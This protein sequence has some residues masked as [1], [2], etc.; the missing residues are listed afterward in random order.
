MKTFFTIPTDNG[1]KLISI[2]TSKE[3]DKQRMFDF[4][5][6]FCNDLFWDL[7]MNEGFDVSLTRGIAGDW[8]LEVWGDNGV[9]TFES[10]E[11]IS[12]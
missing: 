5:K 4:F 11:E 3:L 9:R 12:L 2:D 7:E 1:D 6:T 8:D 10:V